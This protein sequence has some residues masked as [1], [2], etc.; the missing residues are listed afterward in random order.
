MSVR[1]YIGAR[2]V[3]KFSDVNGGVWDSQYSYEALTIVKNGNDFYTSKIPVPVGVDI[4]NDVYW[5]KTG[6]YNGA[7]NSLTERLD[8]ID[9]T[10]GDMYIFVSDYDDDTNPIQAAIDVAVAI[11]QGTAGASAPIIVISK[12]YTVTNISF[13]LGVRFYATKNITLTQPAAISSAMV[14]VGT[15]VGDSVL[16]LEDDRKMGDIFL[17]SRITFVKDGSPQLES[18]VCF[19]LVHD[20]VNTHYSS[21]GFKIRNVGIYNFGIGIADKNNATNIYIIE[22]AYIAAC[23]VGIMFDSPSVNAGENIKINNTIIDHCV[24]CV[25]IKAHTGL[26]TFTGCSFD[27]NGCF[28][29]NESLGV[30]VNYTNGWIEA[31]GA[32]FSMYP[33]SY[34][35]LPEFGKFIY[36]TKSAQS[37]TQTNSNYYCFLN[38]Y[39]NYSDGNQKLIVDNETPDFVIDIDK[40][41]ACIVDF[42]T[43]YLAGPNIYPTSYDTLCI[44]QKKNISILL[45]KPN[46]NSGVKGNLVGNVFRNNYL[47]T[48]QTTTGAAISAGYL[49]ALGI[50]FD[51]NDVTVTSIN[52]N[53]GEPNG[54]RFAVPSGTTLNIFIDMHKL[55]KFTFAACL[56]SNIDCYS[57]IRNYVSNISLD[58][59]VYDRVSTV[60]G[61]KWLVGTDYTD[62]NPEK[63]TIQIGIVASSAGAFNVDLKGLYIDY[64]E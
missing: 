22:D 5:V 40:Y 63:K 47:R 50:R 2:Y 9:N 62:K 19:E 48:G 25:D 3:P 58:R 30:K 56:A 10:F 7:I 31:L 33:E 38:T 6:D 55:S 53:N 44:A 24:I 26:I 14:T 4:L 12:D 32:G 29:K 57:Y 39:I 41:P 16:P 45:P 61:D 59:L 52:D 51:R 13:P 42:N 20:T 37:P 60:D 17:G 54:M 21:M 36:E 27:Y 35:N 34:K 46:C 49:T 11:M 23:I 64:H 43:A 1:Q 8:E 18:A 28:I 15:N